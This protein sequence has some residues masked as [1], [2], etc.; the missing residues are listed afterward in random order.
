M[1]QAVLHSRWTKWAGLLALV[2]AVGFLAR[3][4]FSQGE[5]GG[6]DTMSLKGQAAPDFSLQTLDGK[7]F[8]LSDQKG[9]VVMLDFWAT[10]CPPCRES[11]PHVQKVATDPALAKKGLK[12]YGV[13]AQETAD[14]IKPFM[15]KNK[16]TFSVPM[17]A[18][19]STMQAYLIQ[20]I[21][22]TIIVGREGTIKD[23]F[24]G[25]GGDSAKAIDAAVDKALNEPAK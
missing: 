3:Q 15:A 8:K 17:D 22:T 21:P 13:N 25:Y 12:V 16:Y 2:A 18:G 4:S 10:W 24:I 1:E 6:K 9:N 5:P 20:G 19:G 14:T 11:L 23:V 7:S